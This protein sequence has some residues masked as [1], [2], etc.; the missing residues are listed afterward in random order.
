MEEEEGE[1]NADDIEEEEEEVDEEP[2]DDDDNDNVEKETA[3]ESSSPIIF[4]AVVFA[5]FVGVIDLSTQLLLNP[6]RQ[7]CN[8]FRRFCSIIVIVYI[9]MVW[10]D[11][12]RRFIILLCVGSFFLTLLTL[13]AT[14]KIASIETATIEVPYK[15]N[16]VCTKSAF[17]D[18][19]TCRSNEVHDL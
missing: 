7:Y 10:K 5:V 17:V 8:R 6:S 9:L 14:A 2:E 15:Y 13:A 12:Y 4:F 1:R 19:G 3:V 18:C 11:F 16:G